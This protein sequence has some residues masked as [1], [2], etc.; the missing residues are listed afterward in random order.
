IWAVPTLICKAAMALVMGAMIKHHA[1]GVKGRVLW[2][3]SALAGGLTQGVGYVIFW[4]FLFGKAA[5]IAAIPGLAFQAISGIIIAFVISEALQKTSLRRHFI[6]STD[7]K[8]AA[9]C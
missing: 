2:I 3:V 8:G 5:A 9:E 4:Y 1:F 7:G 6:Y